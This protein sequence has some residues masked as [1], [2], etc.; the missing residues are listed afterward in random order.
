[1]TTMSYQIKNINKWK[2]PKK[3]ESEST[4]WMLLS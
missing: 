3:R 2:L 1:M 4:K